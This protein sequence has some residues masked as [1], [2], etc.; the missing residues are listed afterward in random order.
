MRL[1]LAFVFA[2]ALAAC[3]GSGSSTP[4]ETE[5]QTQQAKFE[6]NMS[7]SYQFDT[8]RSCECT[9]ETTREMRVTVTNG[10]ISGAFYLDDETQVSAQV[11]EHVMTIEETFE[12]IQGAIDDDAH[13]IHVEYDTELGFP[14]SVSIDYSAQIADEELS[15]DIRNVQTLVE[16]CGRRPCG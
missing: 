8:R 10:T 5:L 13:V 3:T 7:D 14:K 9:S 4:E 15:L 1:P 2:S 11:L 12:E 6:T 16:T